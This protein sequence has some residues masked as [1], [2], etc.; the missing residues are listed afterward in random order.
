MNLRMVAVGALVMGALSACASHQEAVDNG[1]RDEPIP[2]ASGPRP[3]AAEAERIVNLTHT[4][5]E[6]TLGQ[7]LAKAGY[8]VSIDYEGVSN[9]RQLQYTNGESI[10]TVNV[11]NG[12]ALPWKNEDLELI[13][14]NGCTI[15]EK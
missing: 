7:C 4:I 12:K 3:S 1:Y 6:L 5:T 13:R 11:F 14:L 10:L 9:S 2:V 15:R 8:Q